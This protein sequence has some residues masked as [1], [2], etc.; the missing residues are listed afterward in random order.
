MAAGTPADKQEKLSYDD[1]NLE[2]IVTFPPCQNRGFG[3][4]LIEFSEPSPALTHAKLTQG[5]YLTKHPSTRYASGSPGTPERP[6]SDLGLKGYTEYWI[7]T[8]LRVCR[9]LLSDAPAFVADPNKTPG[10]ADIKARRR[11]GQVET[12][13]VEVNGIGE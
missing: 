11:G 2:C 6:L 3:K 5:Y 7:S 13:V 10:K 9:D 8:V 12:E 1:F 4:L